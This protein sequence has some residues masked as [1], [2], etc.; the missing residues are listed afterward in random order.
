[1]F[2]E[3][4]PKLKNT[5]I[6]H[7]WSTRSTERS[8]PQVVPH[9]SCGCCGADTTPISRLS[10]ART[11]VR[12]VIAPFARVIERGCGAGVRGSTGARV[13]RSALRLDLEPLRRPRNGICS[14]RCGRPD[15]VG[16]A[17]GR[18]LQPAFR[19]QQGKSPQGRRPAGHRRERLSVARHPGHPGLHAPG[20]RR[21]VGRRGQL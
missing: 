11:S 8:H 4:E 13:P 18:L 20:Q 21:S 7:R 9:D 6:R 3:P 14:R 15:R 10:A 17:A 19:R 5:A 1:M 12:L 16:T 2:P